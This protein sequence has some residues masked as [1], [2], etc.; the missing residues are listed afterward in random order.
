MIF[1]VNNALSSPFLKMFFY[2]IIAGEY[3]G[4]WSHA[5]VGFM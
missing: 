3:K 4:K 1:F 2:S 5:E